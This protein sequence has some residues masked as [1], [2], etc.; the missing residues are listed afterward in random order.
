MPLLFVEQA[1]DSRQAP[2]LIGLVKLGR[3]DA[4]LIQARTK[5]FKR[6][7]VAAGQGDVGGMV[8][9]RATVLIGVLDGGVAGLNS[10][11]R[12]GEIAARDGV[13]VVLGSD[14]QHDGSLVG[15]T[16]LARSRVPAQVAAK[17]FRVHS[18]SG[19]RVNARSPV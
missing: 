11:L 19:R 16:I 3:W 7:R 18:Y 13:Q 14:L 15:E 5:L 2:V 12:D 1:R 17:F 4:L 6:V 10:L 9:G 8:V